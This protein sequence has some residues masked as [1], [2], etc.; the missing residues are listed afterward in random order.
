M[1]ISQ[2]LIGKMIVMVAATAALPASLL[3]AQVPNQGTW[4]TALLARD[5][6]GNLGNG[7]EAYYDVK[8]NITWLAD[9]FYVRTSQYS[10]GINYGKGAPLIWS[11]AKA[12]VDNL[13]LYGITDWRLPKSFLAPGTACPNLTAGGS[14]GS[15]V[16]PESSE[17]AYMNH[18]ILG[19]ISYLSPQGT[20]ASHSGLTNTGPFVNLLPG[21]YW[22]ETETDYRFAWAFNFNFGSQSAEVLKDNQASYV[23]AV[24]DGDRGTAISSVPEPSALL[25]SIVGIGYIARTRSRR[26]QA[27][28]G[29]QGL[30]AP[31]APHRN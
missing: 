2:K 25:L 20:I 17:M 3:A 30:V 14:C 12:W 4:E 11:H 26:V 24:L 8:Q 10:P 9:A 18:V 22:S 27:G 5:L 23:W 21:T 7:P 13:A 6:D 28:Q 31:V 19:N 15:N 29:S 16:I 1:T